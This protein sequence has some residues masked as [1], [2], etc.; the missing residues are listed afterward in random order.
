MGVSWLQWSCVGVLL[1]PC[2]ALLCPGWEVWGLHQPCLPAAPRQGAV[3]ANLRGLDPWRQ[4]SVGQ[5]G[6]GAEAAAPQGALPSVVPAASGVTHVLHSHAAPDAQHEALD[7][8][9]VGTAHDA[10]VAPLA[11]AWAPGVGRRLGTRRGREQGDG[12]EGGGGEG[13]RA[14]GLTQYLSILPSGSVSSPHL[15]AR[16]GGGRALIHLLSGALTQGL[17]HP[18]PCRLW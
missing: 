18:G 17:P 3:S 16:A 6:G 10:E 11:P 13:G 4:S 5:A 2:Q 14:Q 15:R 7:V 12:S 9:L 8:A 1:Y